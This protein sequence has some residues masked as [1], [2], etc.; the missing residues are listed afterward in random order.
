MTTI[1]N[2][3]KLR[4][5][6]L[7]NNIIVLLFFFGI[8]PLAILF[9]VFQ[10]VFVSHQQA[11]IST[12][13]QTN[14]VWLAENVSGY[15]D[16]SYDQVKTLG[17]MLGGEESSEKIAEKQKEFL[18]QHSSFEQIAV[19]DTQGCEI[20]RMARNYTYLPSELHDRNSDS[21]T[22]KALDGEKAAIVLDFHPGSSTPMIKFISPIRDSANHL[23]GWLEAEMNLNFFWKL[24]SKTSLNGNHSVF[25]IDLE[26]RC[27]M[28][29]TFFLSLSSNIIDR[30]PILGALA[31]GTTGVW[32][33]IGFQDQKVIGASAIIPATGWGVIV[34]V[35]VAIAYG[36]LFRIVIIFLGLFAITLIAAVVRGL[37]FSQ[38]RII[39]PVRALQQEIEGLSQGIFPEVLN[40][41]G[42][43]ELGQ[44]S[45]AFDQMV[46]HLK[47]TMVSKNLLSREITERKQVEEVLRRREATLR[48]IFLTVPLGIG[49][50]HDWVLA[51]GND[52][53]YKMTGYSKEKIRNGDFGNLFDQQTDYDIVRKQVCR[54]L[55]S[56]ETAVIE[57]RWRRQD[58]QVREIF[59]KFAATDKPGSEADLVFAAMD[60]SDLRKMEQE[61]LRIDKLES[62]GILAGGIAHDFNN[63]LT[64]ILGNIELVG[65]EMRNPDKNL[66][67]LLEAEQACQRAQHLAKQ[68]LTFA[69]G[70]LPIKKPIIVADLLQDVVPLA[71]SGSNSAVEML[72]DENV[73]PIEIDEDQIHQVINNI[74]INADQAM[75]DGGLVTIK[76]QNLHITSI[77]GL[78]L[79][80]GNY[81]RFS[82]IDEG[83]GISPK[84]LDKIFDPYYT[85]KQFGN[86]LGLTTAF[87]I[88]KNHQGYI[89]IESEPGQG[90]TFHLYLP[91]A[92]TATQ[93]SSAK[94]S[95]MPI[96]GQGRILVM[97]DEASIR[98]VLGHMLHKLGYEAVSVKDG[99]EALKAYKLALQK[100]EYFD[101]VILD[102]TIPNGLGGKETLDL[103]LEL[104]RHIQAVLSSGY[105]DDPIMA[106]Y[107]QYGFKSVIAKPYKISELGLV[108]HTVLSQKKTC[109]ATF[110]N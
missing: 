94:V 109:R 31:D 91:A 70:G 35:P 28:A 62:L 48:S 16:K 8:T 59:L 32:E 61:R 53:F 5:S 83:I 88:I 80:D 76:V 54:T 26:K 44:L 107:Q 4:H 82:I 27:L 101:A 90:T 79:P 105:G 22:Q 104:D 93:K 103:L 50:L 11:N 1:K 3:W 71:L 49:S 96:R 89:T 23:I 56:E 37:I 19:L 33:Y 7:T 106:N 74:L 13:Q 9:L 97:D 21:F 20:A 77:L 52:F 78:P 29:K 43:D 17:E 57:T 67:R 95:T 102:L 75:P 30:L 100:K 25:I 63:I 72:V 40:V 60:I 18:T 55:E 68:L 42:N 6:T 84:N 69:K 65:L 64:I 86:G 47:K 24:T 12:L 58:G 98:E 85:T 66:E 38:H 46:E 45:K 2:L 10:H 36:P 51:G 87:S 34:E 108:L 39:G 41:T 99:L 81:V 15:V 110:K 73:W 92:K 14:A